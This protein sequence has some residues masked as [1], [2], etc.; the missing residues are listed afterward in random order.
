VT[1]TVA[2]LGELGAVGGIL[3]P[4]Y[5]TLQRLGATWDLTGYTAPQLRVW[6]LL[7]N[8]VLTLTGTAAIASPATSGVVSYTP[9]TADPI[10]AAAGIYEGRVWLTPPGGGAKEPSAR[11]RYSIGPGPGAA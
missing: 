3:R 6:D 7:T 9:G 10:Y 5:L 1:E 8:T 4:L 11:F 2:W